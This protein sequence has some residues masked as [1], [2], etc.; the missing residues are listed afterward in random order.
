MTKAQRIKKF[1]KM[2]PNI[3]LG[4]RGQIV[5]VVGKHGFTYQQI[6]N[7]LMDGLRAEQ[8]LKNMEDLDLLPK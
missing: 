7:S 1:M 8:A 6:F 3:P 2:Y 4:A 5:A